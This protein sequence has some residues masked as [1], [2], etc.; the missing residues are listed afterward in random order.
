MGSSLPAPDTHC[1]VLYRQTYNTLGKIVAAGLT[2]DNRVGNA[3][4]AN[5]TRLNS[6]TN[7]HNV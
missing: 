7:K 1:D 6:N 2:Q 5:N 4:K 3:Q